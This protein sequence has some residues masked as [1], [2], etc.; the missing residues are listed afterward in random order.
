ME[1]EF[2]SSVNKELSKHLEM[3]GRMPIEAIDNLSPIDVSNILNHLFQEGSPVQYARQLHAETLEQVPFFMLF[4]EY[5]KRIEASKE[6]KLTA[7]GNLLRKVCKELYGLGLIKEKMIEQGISTL[8]KEEDSVVLQ[9]LKIIGNLSGIT[10]KR[11]N[12]LSL[13]KKGEKLI[14][15]GGEVNLFKQLFETNV[16][17]FNL[18]Y[19]DLY[20]SKY[21]QGTFGYTLY[22]LIRYG[23]ETRDIKFYSDKVLEAF[24]QLLNEFMDDDW[25]TP[26]NRFTSCYQVRFFD[27]LLDF[28]GFVT[29]EKVKVPERVSR[30]VKVG[31]TPLFRSVFEIKPENFQ[32]LKTKHSS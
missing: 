26:Q 23:A 8:N 18:G 16:Q 10:K 1:D 13:T 32:F 12:K 24:P 20:P 11:N 27:R 28:Y 25:S 14:Q 31:T 21:L 5:L 30:Q 29:L 17:K 22:L 15:K 9:N 4:R 3:L 6:M 2:I 19:H 7:K